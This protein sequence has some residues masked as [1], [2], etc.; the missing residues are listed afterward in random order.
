MNEIITIRKECLPAQFLEN[1][2][3]EFDSQF[4]ERLN[5]T[6]SLKA[7]CCKLSE[8]AHFVIA[9]QNDRYVGLVA[10]YINNINKELFIPYICVRSSFRKMGI[11]DSMME[12][13]C[14]EADMMGFD[15]S[16]EVRNNNIS[17]RK[18][19]FKHGFK[20]LIEGEV[21]SLMKR[22]FSKKEYYG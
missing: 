15:V 9:E 8:N 21:K 2:F 6:V 18:L 3:L 16:L 12:Y 10:F 13:V 14:K 22:I 20:I 5:Q 1:L 17:A 11:A 19:Y 4:A 7:Y